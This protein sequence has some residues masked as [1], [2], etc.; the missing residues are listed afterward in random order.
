MVKTFSTRSSVTCSD[1]AIPTL[2]QRGTRVAYSSEEFD[3]CRRLNRSLFI[4]IIGIG[5]KFRVM[6]A[7]QGPPGP[8]RIQ[9]KT[10]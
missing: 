9:R 1:E 5:A 4:G 2:S 3:R 10:T 7:A 6:V 8:L